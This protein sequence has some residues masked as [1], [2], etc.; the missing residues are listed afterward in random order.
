VSSTVTNYYECK[1]AH[2]FSHWS[3]ICLLS[4]V[5]LTT[6]DSK[7]QW[8]KQFEAGM[9]ELAE[10]GVEFWVNPDTYKAA[11]VIKNGEVSAISTALCKAGDWFHESVGIAI[12]AERMLMGMS[13]MVRT[14]ELSKTLAGILGGEPEDYED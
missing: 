7:M 4:N 5:A 11:C 6:G 8:S 1:V 14:N 2:F 9:A 13:I 12:S 10:R 3:I